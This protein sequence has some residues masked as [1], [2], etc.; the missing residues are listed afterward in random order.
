M[1]H[2]EGK[3]VWSATDLMNSLECDHLT[4]LDGLAVRGKLQRPRTAGPLEARGRIGQ[5]HERE[6]LDRLRA[7]GLSVREIT[8][9]GFSID[10]LRKADMATSAA[11][12]EG[13]DVIYQATFF[14]ERREPHFRGHADFL[15]KVDTPS[16]LGDHSYEV[17]DAKASR[18]VPR[19]SVYQLGAYSE[20]VARIQGRPPARMHLWLGDGSEVT[21]FAA[22]E[23]DD[24][25]RVRDEFLEK[26]GAT[27]KETYPV[28]VAKCGTCVWAS[29]CTAQ[30]Q[31]DE[32]VS[33]VYGLRK[34]QLRSLLDNGVTTLVDVL[35]VDDAVGVP[36]V[37]TTVM[38]GIKAR[39]RLQLE[40]L[41]TGRVRFEPAPAD[42]AR[43][44]LE[45]LPVPSRFD[46]AV[47]VRHHPGVRPTGL[48]FLVSM[49]SRE[50]GTIQ[51]KQWWNEDRRDERKSFEQL[52]D[53]LVDRTSK[54][55]EAH[56]F[57]YGGFLP[58]VLDELSDRYRTRR[59][60]VQ[61]LVDSGALVDMSPIVRG[62]VVV[63][64]ESLSLREIETLYDTQRTTNVRTS[65]EAV[66]A[67]TRYRAMGDE[68]ERHD[69]RA[70]GAE[71]ATSALELR[72]W[73][74]VR[75]EDLLGREARNVGRDRPAMLVAILPPSL[76]R[77]LAEQEVDQIGSPFLGARG[78]ELQAS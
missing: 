45:A 24:Y 14:D 61:S 57:H 9:D 71:T 51:H 3:L 60:Q 47:D 37:P 67:F 21:Y 68:E 7:E 27:R 1:Q 54:H 46:V 58:K 6:I 28:R 39:A 26:I 66:E 70:Y 15:V 53:A 12:K 75:R 17:V 41:R 30:R 34:D 69:L 8:Y 65:T 49:A 52:V 43:R 77:A 76:R 33:L 50:R 40:Q 35:A 25:Q 64:V 48:H 13:V 55:P 42:Q 11:M 29:R 31:K 20:Q 62:S 2:I 56:V 36:G 73:L 16:R 38:Q 23:R 5:Q 78:L 4:H 63:S 19:S 10:G 18:K 72:D 59:R 32:H 22:D 74:E 44:A